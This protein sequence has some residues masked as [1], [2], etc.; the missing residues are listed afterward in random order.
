MIEDA[1]GSIAKHPLVY[2]EYVSGFRRM[3]VVPF[4]YLL[5]FSAH[6]GVVIVDALLHV[7]RS[8]ET[9]R[10]ILAERS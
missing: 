1:L 3:V 9:N 2:V 5:V 10:A 8:P 4:P 6:D 7:R